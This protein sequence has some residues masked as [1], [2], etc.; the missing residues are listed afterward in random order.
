MS[1]DSHTIDR[2]VAGVLEQLGKQ[3]EGVETLPDQGASPENNRAYEVLEQVVTASVLENLRDE[4]CILVG[5]KTIVTPAAWDAARE[6]GIEILRQTATP[7]RNAASPS[8]PEQMA[9]SPNR[10]RPSRGLLAVVRNSEDLEAFYDN[11]KN[12]WRRELLSCPDDAA[13]LAIAELSR[14]AISTAVILA[15]QAHR[16]ACLANRNAS[17]KAV[18]IRD[19]SDIKEIRKQ[20]RAN[21]WCLNPNGKSWFELHRLLSLIH[22]FS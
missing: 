12:R 22:S 11:D 21:V 19:V 13:K 10:N 4:K 15:E 8:Q 1:F 9:P 5:A 14:G 17:V 3:A 6:W 20:L 18:A 2:I 7:T 16:A